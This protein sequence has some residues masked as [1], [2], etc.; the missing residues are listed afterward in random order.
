MN[1]LATKAQLSTWYRDVKLHLVK[2]MGRCRANSDGDCN[3]ADCP[4][5]H[6]NEP[7]KSGRHCPRDVRD[8]AE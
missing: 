1:P 5:L 8:D 7:A 3:Q 2:A 6:D 4:Q